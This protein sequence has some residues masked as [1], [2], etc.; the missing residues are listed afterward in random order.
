MDHTYIEEQQ[1]A[2]RYVMG[3]LP[4]GEA[5]SFEAHYLSCP[6]CL[7]RLE[8]AEAMRRGFRRAAGEDAAR[9][10]AA[11]QLAVVAWL[12]RLGRSRQAAVL[13]MA[14]LVA[15][16]VPA[17]LARRERAGR[18]GELAGVRSALAEERERGAAAAERAGA[19]AE[20]LRGE[21]AASRQDLDRER[22]TAARASAELAAEL[23]RARAPQANVPILFLA[24]ERSGGPA[25]GGPTF[26][27]R[28]P[29]APGR[30]VLALEVDPPHHASY[31]VV[32]RDAGGGELW[33]GAD[34]RV[35][36]MGT[37]SLSLPAA[38]LAPGDYTVAV[39]GAA[40]GALPAPPSRFAFR[41]LPR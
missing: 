26:R 28:L 40:P 9:V 19:E 16:L 13:T 36:E 25:G 7:D 33:R 39:E 41:V 18:D 3:K 30:V 4:D 21:L 22:E 34:L 8:V 24:A 5:A 12:A 10:A 6:Q 23:E 29:P 11:R 1:V 20:R 27:L 31:R 37:L 35:N 17:G 38:L 14:L 15:V 32:L 2:D